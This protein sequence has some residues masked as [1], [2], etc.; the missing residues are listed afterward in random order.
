METVAGAGYSEDPDSDRAGAEAAAAAMKQAG[1]K[2]CDLALLFSTARHD[3]RRLLAAVRRVVGVHARIIGGGTAGIIT[4]ERLGYDGAQVGVAVIGSDS[5]RIETFTAPGLA[6]DEQRAGRMLAGRLR[7]AVAA[8]E[9]PVV[10]MYESVKRSTPEGPQLNMGTPLLAGLKA[11]LGTWPPIVGM[12]LHGDPQWK[13]GLQY[14]DDQLK[15]QCVMAFRLSGG[16]RMDTVTITNLRPM[17]TY[18]TATRTDGAALLEID[19][20][21]ALDV[22]EELV[23]PAVPSSNYPLMVT[24]GV[25]RGDK[26]GDFREEDYAIHLCV[27]VDPPRRALLMDSHVAAGVEFQLMRRHLDFAQIRQRAQRLLER[28]AQRR[29][30]LALYIDCAGRTSK[31]AGTD[32]EEAAEIQAVIGDRMP[33]FGMYSGGEVANVGGDVQRLTNAGVLAIFSE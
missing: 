25:N 28:V 2:R 17:S 7:E 27:A 22:V 8:T 15:S 26:F 21:P 6:D 9:A 11:G 33:L 31:Y 19:G 18:R 30:F 20:R 24:L 12:A 5:V 23:G 1:Y 3:Q 29:A 16:V 13:P 4:N 10:L 14:F 32:R